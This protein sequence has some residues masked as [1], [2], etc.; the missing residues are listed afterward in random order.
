M[1][2]QYRIIG[3]F[4]SEEKFH[5]VDGGFKPFTD[6]AVA[7]KRLNELIEQSKLEMKFKQRKA[8][9]AGYVSIGTEYHS[10]YDLLDLR[11]QEREVTPWN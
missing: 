5:V 6:Y 9:N 1:K 2:K 8:E 10:D 3:R 11:I 7:E 4:R